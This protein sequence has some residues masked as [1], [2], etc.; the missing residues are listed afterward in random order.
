M[1]GFE[2]PFGTD[3][4][5]NDAFQMDDM[6]ITCMLCFCVRCGI[7][8]DIGNRLK[9]LIISMHLRELHVYIK[10]IKLHITTICF[11]LHVK[12]YWSD[13]LG[14]FGAFKYSN[15]IFE[16]SSIIVD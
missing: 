4:L 9:Y 5:L 6:P 3:V 12:Y 11:P 7:V 13:N 15:F 1:K 14:C 16:S 10:F 2:C 8:T